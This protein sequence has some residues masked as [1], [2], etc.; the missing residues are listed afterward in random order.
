MKIGVPTEIKADESRIAIVPAGVHALAAAGHDVFVQAGAGEGS[1]FTDD[2][3]ASAGATLKPNAKALHDAAELIVKVKEP[4]V[5]EAA[6]YRP[7]QTIF[8]YFHFAA[9]DDVAQ[10]CIEAEVMAIAYETVRDRLGR[11]CLLTPMSEIAGKM[12]VQEGAKYLERPNGGRGVLLGGVPGVA[13]ANV[14][15]LGGG[16]VGT[17]AAKIAAGF[18]AN[19]DILDV[20]LDRLRYLDDVMPAN[21]HTVFSD[22]HTIS[23]YCSRADLVVGAVLIPG[24][25][26]PR[27]VTRE[28]LR[29]MQTGAVVVDVAVDQGGCFETSRPTTHHDPTFVVDGV[30]HYCVSNMPGAVSRTSTIALCNA[31]LPYV[32][33]LANHGIAKALSKDAGLREGVNLQAGRVTNEAVAASLNLPYTPLAA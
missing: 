8:A 14:V 6:M 13:P 9:A 22:A 19:V 15:I 30:V 1:G 2:E 26:A 11:L 10:A 21:V 23:N 27:L 31:T 18:G 5:S 17:C 32:T 25:K 4:Q 12:S 24:A 29:R 33:A 20:N 16:I 7:N 28:M 3:F